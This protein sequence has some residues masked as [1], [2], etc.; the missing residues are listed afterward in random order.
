M[1]ILY[2]SSFF[3]Q[4][5]G[6]FHNHA[7]GSSATAYDTVR[8][9]DDCSSACPLVAPAQPSWVQKELQSKCE[10]PAHIPNAMT[11]H[12]ALAPG[13]EITSDYILWHWSNDDY[14]PNS[15]VNVTPEGFFGEWDWE[16]LPPKIVKAAKA[17]GYTQTIWEEDRG[18]PSAFEKYWKELTS[19]EREAAKALGYTDNSWNETEE[20]E[21]PSPSPSPSPAI[22]SHHEDDNPIYDMD[23]SEL[24]DEQRK[25]ALALGYNEVDWGAV[26]DNPFEDLY[27][28]QLTPEQQT[29]A[30]TIGYNQLSWDSIGAEEPWFYCRC[31]DDKCQSA[32]GFR[33]LKY[34]PIEEQKR[35]YWVVEP[36]VRHQ[37]DWNLYQLEQEKEDI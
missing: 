4:V 19:E 12:R 29:S 9:A 1:L 23:W 31:G 36:Y 8:L 25:A 22:V 14:I 28:Y 13:D 26:E 32:D 34:L 30:A 37:I 11:T 18:D 15:P 5:P 6:H 21:S 20:E 16:E 2:F 7:C 33:G 17:L 3:K 24:E 10:Y 27:W 35:L